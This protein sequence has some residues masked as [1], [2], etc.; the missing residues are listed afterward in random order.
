MLI[1]IKLTQALL[2]RPQYEFPHP[3]EN[4]SPILAQAQIFINW[5]INVAMKI[6]KAFLNSLHFSWK[7][8]GEG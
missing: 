3:I 1:K 7:L 2:E 6:I 5:Q 4:N 8:I